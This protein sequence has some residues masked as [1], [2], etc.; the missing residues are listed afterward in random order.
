MK[1]SYYSVIVMLLNLKALQSAYS[2]WSSFS[3][4]EAVDFSEGYGVDKSYPIHHHIK[5]RESPYWGA[6]Y[7]DHMERCAKY[8][9]ARECKATE[10]ARLEM[11]LNQPKTQVNYT[12]LGFEKRKAPEKAWEIIKGFW[13]RHKNS[14]VLESWPRGYT[15]VN[16]WESPTD[17]VSFENHDF[18]E[19]KS[20]K[21]QIWDAMKPVLEDWV[22]QELQPTS[23]YGIRVYKDKAIL[24]THVDR[25]PLV[26]SCIIQ[27][28]QDV[29]E[30]WPIE[31]YTHDGQA[32]NVTMQPGD[33]VMY[34]S[35]SV[36]HGR[37]FP[38]NGS[39][40]ANVFIHFQP[41]NH[42]ENNR[43]AFGGSDVDKRAVIN[44]LKRNRK[45]E[46]VG[47][48]AENHDIS[49]LREHMLLL[50][51]SEGHN[52]PRTGNL[53]AKVAD[54][55]RLTAAKGDI[56]GL[57]T[58]LENEADTTLVNAMDENNWTALHEASRAGHIDCVKYLVEMGA[59]IGGKTAS[60]ETAF[61]LARH[62]LEPTDP[63]IK[64]F[65]NIRAP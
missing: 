26:T 5:N 14:P 1:L 44:R 50:K 46:V 48:E 40:Y 10:N 30:L 27:V 51:D 53:I 65:E 34:E 41:V 9:S 24:A 45:M 52:L 58:I 60:G 11:N 20:A 36:L 57:V 32:V 49:K 38:M 16:T 47:H 3:K 29:N 61:E 4:Q 6:L 62:E 7:D 39:H 28:S 55:L 13:D 23:L 22:G 33:M 17:M 31:V 18:A 19:G 2:L 35:H 25:L 8:Y 63:V 59:D 43:R 12:K 64:Y 15:Y 56:M 54:D 42:V 21:Q 37:P